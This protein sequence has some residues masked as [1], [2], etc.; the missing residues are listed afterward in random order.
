MDCV[1]IKIRR[2]E[3]SH[4][5]LRLAWVNPIATFIAPCQ[6]FNGG[7]EGSKWLPRAHEASKRPCLAFKIP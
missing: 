1:P 2:G 4:A 6:R 5:S 3:P 7:E